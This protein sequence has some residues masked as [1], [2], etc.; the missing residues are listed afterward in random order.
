MSTLG[1]AVGRKIL[2]YELVVSSDALGRVPP[3]LVSDFLNTVANKTS[4]EF[5]AIAGG[6]PVA[7]PAFGV[8]VMASKTAIGPLPGPHGTTQNVIITVI[9]KVQPCGV[10]MT[11]RAIAK[12]KVEG[13]AF[14]ATPQPLDTQIQLAPENDSVKLGCLRQY[15]AGGGVLKRICKL[16]SETSR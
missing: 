2:H 3:E 15:I 13:R 16:A 4:V 8:E 7:L 9:L 1:L 12:I 5:T 10:D 14:W 6:V 11:L